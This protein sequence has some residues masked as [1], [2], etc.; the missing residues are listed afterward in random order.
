[1][2]TPPSVPIRLRSFSFANQTAHFP[3]TTQNAPH[4]RPTL[5]FRTF[6]TCRRKT[7]PA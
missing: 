6:V 2:K 7:P 1:M 4:T 5:G 3:T